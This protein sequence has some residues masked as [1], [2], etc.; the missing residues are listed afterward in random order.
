MFLGTHWMQANVT[1]EN[2]AEW[3]RR[4]V[5]GTTAYLPPSL[6]ETLLQVSYLNAMPVD[7]HERRREFALL[8]GLLF[9]WGHMYRN[10]TEHQPQPESWMWNY[11]P[12][13]D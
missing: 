11:F 9:V 6:N 4:H 12:D 2:P 10:K 5:T 7:M 13:G 8:A 3:I 1:G